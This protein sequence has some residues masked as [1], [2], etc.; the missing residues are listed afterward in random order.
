MQ[1][2][3]RSME[4][5]KIKQS[6]DSFFSIVGEANQLLNDTEVWKMAK[7]DLE[8]AKVVFAKLLQ[9]LELLTNIAEIILPE[10]APRM[11][12]MLGDDKQVGE[13]RILFERKEV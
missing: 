13:A 8:G 7:V 10:T 2:F 1:L 3:E 6:I 4:E 12:E 11:R 9:Y 5:K